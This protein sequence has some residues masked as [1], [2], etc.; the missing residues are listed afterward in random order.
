LAFRFLKGYF[1]F[2]ALIGNYNL[3]DQ[4]IEKKLFRWFRRI[5]FSS[6]NTIYFEGYEIY[7]VLCS[8]QF[9]HSFLLDSLGT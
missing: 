2:L 8:Q 6:P 1:Y 3:L 5:I 7:T 9:C 4:T